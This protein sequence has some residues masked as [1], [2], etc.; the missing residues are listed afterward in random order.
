R[1]RRAHRRE[2]VELL[3][4]RRHHPGR[5]PARIG[6]VP[7][8]SHH[9]AVELAQRLLGHRRKGIAVLFVPALADRQRSPVDVEPLPRGGCLHH[10]DAF[11]NDFETDV[12]AQQDTDLQ[13]QS[14]TRMP[15]SST[16]RFQLAI[17][18]L[19]QPLASSSAVRR[20][21][22]IPPRAKAACI[23][24]TLIAA[25]NALRSVSMMSGGTADGAKAATHCAART[26]GK[27]TSAS[28]GTSACCESRCSAAMASA[29]TRPAFIIPT[30]L[31]ML[32]HDRQGDKGGRITTPVHSFCP[33]LL[34]LLPLFSDISRHRVTVADRVKSLPFELPG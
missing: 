25:T 10:L 24:G 4:H 6:G 29:R 15:V 31:V 18:A 33:R 12:V 8:R 19:S 17:S 23:S 28:V 7:D 21:T 1:Q 20:G 9:P 22:S 5:I 11:R 27:P 30:G 14:S 26:P 16:S 13:A 3:A 34:A 32:N 2:Q